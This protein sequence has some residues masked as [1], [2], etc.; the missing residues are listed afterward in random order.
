MG[1][2]SRALSKVTAVVLLVFAEAVTPCLGAPD[3]RG[4]FADAGSFYAGAQRG[5]QRAAQ[6]AARETR[7]RHAGAPRALVLAGLGLICLIAHR[8]WRAQRI[9]E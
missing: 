2:V 7:P 6:S 8:R 1:R 4:V 9:A 3:Y 5:L